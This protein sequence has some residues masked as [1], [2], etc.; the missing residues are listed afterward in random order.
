MK[1]FTIFAVAAAGVL[2]ASSEASAA[3]IANGSF[4][5]PIVPVGSFTNFAVGSGLLTGW[6][7]FG[8]AG[9]NVS[10]VSGSFSQN[11]VTFEAEDGNQWLDLTGD[12][13]NSTEGVSQAVTTTTGDQYQLS[14]FIGNTT[15]GGIFGTTSTVDV[16]LNGV[17]TFADTKSNVSPTDLNWEQFTH[18]FVAAGTSTTLAFQNADPANHNSNGLD[19]VVLVDQGPAP[20]PAPLIGFGLPVFLAVGGLWLGGRLLERSRTGVG[21]IRF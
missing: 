13:S 5:T 17:P 4:E 6:T 16:S 14:Y 10:I 1:S 21:V 19:T 9:T 20:V 2:A 7:V 8:L 12:G 15:G 3:L 18:T 11:G